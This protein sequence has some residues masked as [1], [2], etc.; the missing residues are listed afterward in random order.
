MIYLT[1]IGQPPGGSSTVHMY[2]QTIQRA[3][4]NKQY[5]TYNNTIFLSQN[6][7]KQEL[8]N[9]IYF[10]CVHMFF[11]CFHYF[12]YRNYILRILTWNGK[13][14]VVLNLK[15]KV[16]KPAVLS[17]VVY[18]CETLSLTLREYPILGS[19]N[20]VRIY[21]ILFNSFWFL[22]PYNSYLNKKITNIWSLKTAW[23]KYWAKDGG[24]WKRNCILSSYT[25]CCLRQI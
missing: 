24:S 11:A 1:A 17:G 13:I 21:L 5:N 19:L 10:Y 16:Y 7:I 4:Q 20:F 18:S 23:G 12:H 9:G 15:I 6:C 25:V 14:H 3:T 22:F 2:T 8:Y